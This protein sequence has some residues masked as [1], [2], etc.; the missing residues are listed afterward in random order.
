M[1]LR[2]S[3]MKDLTALIMQKLGKVEQEQFFKLKESIANESKSKLVYNQLSTQIFKQRVQRKVQID[4]KFTALL[5]R[6]EAYPG[7]GSNP[8]YQKLLD[9]LESVDHQ[10]DFKLRIFHL[11]AVRVNKLIK[12]IPTSWYNSILLHL[13]EL[14]EARPE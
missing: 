7:I 1:P 9:K 8:Q 6:G 3:I 2:S 4:K 5:E 14:P 10:I 12:K 13:K 11:S